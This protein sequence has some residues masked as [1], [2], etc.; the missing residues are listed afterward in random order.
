MNFKLQLIIDD[1]KGHTC[2][3][4]IIHIM[5]D[6]ETNS[7]G[8]CAGLSLKDS[9]NLLK[10]LQQKLVLYEAEA[11][12]NQHRACPHC[13]KPRR[14][15]GHDSIQYKTL[16][17]IVTI[18]SLR[19]YHCQCDENTTKVK[20]LSLLQDWLPEHTSPELQYLETKWAS[21]MAF[22]KTS[23]LLQD[24][25]PI[26]A[27]HNG[28]T[29]RNHLHKTAKRQ[30]GELE[31]KPRCISGCGNDW[32]KLPKPDK[33]LTVGIDGGYVRS[34]TDKKTNFEIIIGKSFSKTKTA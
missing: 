23:Q 17:G 13:H 26:H 9:K 7:I 18:P 3:E 10:M 29:V 31:G 2:V 24:V 16:F 22:D 21:Y 1:D 34:C 12:T 28:N 6:T 19:L 33:P 5:K 20:T 11:Y 32:A 4:D 8:Y 25:L 27:S 15:K 14:I 30:E